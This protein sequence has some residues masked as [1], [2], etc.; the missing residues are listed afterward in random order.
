ML[1]ESLYTHDNY[2]D[3]ATAKLHILNWPLGQISQTIPGI[4]S[5]KGPQATQ[6][7]SRQDKEETTTQVIN[8]PNQVISMLTIFNWTPTRGL[9]ANAILSIVLEVSALYMDPHTQ[10]TN[11]GILGSVLSL[12]DP[13]CKQNRL[14]LTIKRQ[15]T[16][17]SVMQGIAKTLEKC[18]EVTYPAGNHTQSPLEP[19]TLRAVKRTCL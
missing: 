17:T 6:L 14:T 19:C 11:A 15:N 1:P 4:H 18:Q 10:R 3:G 13:L 16:C 12:Q 7:Q 9:V 5:Y 8:A 2:D